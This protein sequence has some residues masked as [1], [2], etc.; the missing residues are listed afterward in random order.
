M[1]RPFYIIDE[2]VLIAYNEIVNLM[3]G[4][5]VEKEVF[6]YK[7]KLYLDKL[8]DM[9]DMSEAMENMFPKFYVTAEIHITNY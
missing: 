9:S 6:H 7:I 1:H 4:D 2:N 5:G 3:L 8:I